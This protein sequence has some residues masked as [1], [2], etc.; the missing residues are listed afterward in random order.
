MRHAGTD[1]EV[2]TATP[3]ELAVEPREPLLPRPEQPVGREPLPRA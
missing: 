1:V 3:L 2:T